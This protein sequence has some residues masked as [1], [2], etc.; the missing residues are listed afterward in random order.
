M[1]RKVVLTMPFVGADGTATTRAKDGRVAL[2]R[3]GIL[4]GLKADMS[5]QPAGMD[6]TIKDETG[7]TIV[8]FTNTGNT[9]VLGSL[10]VDGVTDDGAAAADLAQG[11]PF[12]S[13]LQVAFTSGDVT[14]D[15]NSITDDSAAIVTLWVEV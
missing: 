15:P 14:L 8:T 12:R 3:P 9:V 1:I 10:V 5:G 2:G 4:I 13:G 6:G 7:N 11:A